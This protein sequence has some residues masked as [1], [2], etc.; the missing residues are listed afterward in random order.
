MKYHH[1][2]KVLALIKDRTNG[3]VESYEHTYTSIKEMK[4]DI[5]YRYHV[6]RMKLVS[7]ELY[8]GSNHK[9]EVSVFVCFSY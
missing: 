9:Y 3:N 6:N 7:P 1:K 8:Q 2:Y 4:N 5:W